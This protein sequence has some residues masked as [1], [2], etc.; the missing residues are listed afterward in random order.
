MKILSKV[1]LRWF[2]K[3]GWPWFVEHIWPVIEEEVFGVF[4]VVVPKFRE[5]LL[6]WFGDRKKRQEEHATRK[7]EQA[8]QRANE[9]QDK[10]EADKYRAVAEVWRDVAEDFRRENEDLKERVDFLLN[11]SASEFR[12]GVQSLAIKDIVEAGEK[13]TFKIKG[14]EEPL[15]LPAPDE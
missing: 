4:A 6:H 10:A 8:D 9:A 3:K 15:S 2:L 13:G 7:A 14:R 5:N 11:Q 12:H 1:L